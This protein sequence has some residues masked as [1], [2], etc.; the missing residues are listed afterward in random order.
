MPK[1]MLSVLI[2]SAADFASL[3][4]GG[5]GAAPA[6]TSMPVNDALG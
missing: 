3:P 1:Y 4:E 2:D 5:A 6:P